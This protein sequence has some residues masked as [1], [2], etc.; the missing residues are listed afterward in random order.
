MR[1][2]IAA[3]LL[4]L[5]A[6]PAF[7]RPGFPP[8]WSASGRQQDYEFGTDAIPGTTGKQ[9]AYVKALP[10]AETNA[11]GGM[12][13]CIKADNY[14][15]QRVRLAA[16]L[17]GVGASA[18]QLWM[19]VDGP[20]PDNYG[21]APMLAFYNN[22]DRRITGTTDWQRA[23]VVLDVPKNSAAICYG[24][25]LAGGK[26]EAWADGLSLSKVGQDVPVSRMAVPFP[27]PTEPANLAFDR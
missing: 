23:E 16:R 20:R 11:F 1:A 15:G 21:I 12:L 22:S 14:L 13:Q 24:F 27:T 17:K 9:A 7:A 25:F 3:F 26:G 10:R 5:L 19:R 2:P 18:I 8:G 6:T 4:L